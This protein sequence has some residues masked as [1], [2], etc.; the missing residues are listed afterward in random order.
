[1]GNSR[2]LAIGKVLVTAGLLAVVARSSANNYTNDC[3]E[4]VA[5]IPPGVCPTWHYQYS[6]KCDCASE[7]EKAIKCRSQSNSTS[8]KFAYCMTFNETSNLTFIG[9]CPY[10]R[11]RGGSLFYSI[12]ENVLKLNDQMCGPLNR[13]GILCSQCQEGLG[14]AAFS[15]YRECLECMDEPYG[16]I[17]YFFMATFPQTILCLFV[18]IFRINVASAPLNGLV[19]AHCQ[20]YP[21][22]HRPKPI[23]WQI[24]CNMLWFLESGHFQLHNPFIL[25]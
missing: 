7:F 20:H 19:L 22:H 3:T 16:W 21:I 12:P 14:P 6:G 24:C 10:N 1:M 17:L 2:L 11:H 8:L 15:L 4:S 9:H 13:T 18:I 5:R 23:L 25:H